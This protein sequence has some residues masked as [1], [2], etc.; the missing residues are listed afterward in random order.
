MKSS[1][2]SLPFAVIVAVA[3]LLGS[4]CA[5]FQRR[6][7]RPSV[8]PV[9]F[10]PTAVSEPTPVNPA[11]L[12]RPSGEFKLG[13]GDQLEIEILGDSATRARTT[14]GP[15]GKIYF[16][17][18]PGIDVWGLTLTQTREKIAQEMQKFVREQQPISISL[19]AVESQRVWILGRLN[20]PGVYTMAGPMTL[21]EAISEAGGPAP[22]STAASFTSTVSGATGLLG[23]N[24][25]GA[26]DEAADLSRSFVVREGRLLKVDF[27]RLL[28][29]GDMSQNIYLQPDD[30]IYLPSGTTGN[31]HVMGAVA[32]ARSVDYL[33]RLTL[34]QAVAQAGGAIRNAYLS[35]VAIVR[36][37][38]TQPQLAVV[39]LRAVL[40]GEIPDVTLEP[41][42]IVFVPYT[43]YR[44]LTRYLDIILDTFVRTVGVNEGARAV[45]GGAVGVSVPLGGP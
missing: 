17:V 8:Q 14:V 4:G 9:A 45:S 28:R 21:L 20:K 23:T 37:S 43:P 29:E 34:A 5:S 26:S 6:A 39:D 35:H 16:Y 18:L 32:T 2:L 24:S 12:Q 44:V 10:T 27:N 15:D 11:L 41:Q 33:G 40:R 1:I 19:R 22:A 36:G 31:V 7:A 30:L 25:R 13:P 3:S 38:L 42:D